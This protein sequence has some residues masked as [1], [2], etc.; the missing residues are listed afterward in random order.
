M[1]QNENHDQVHAQSRD[2][3]EEH[4]FAIDARWVDNALNRFN[5]Q[6]SSHLP[7]YED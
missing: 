2:S 1:A 5:N 6:H 3:Q 4:Q 7:D